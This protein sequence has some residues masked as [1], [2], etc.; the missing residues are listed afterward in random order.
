MSKLLVWDNA[1]PHHP[2]QVK[3]AAL[4]AGFELA[5]L[6]FR[7]PELMPLE[8]LGRRLKDEVAANRCYA[9]MAELAKRAVACWIG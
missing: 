3:A 4:A 2:R 6:P 1:P 7:S 9:T 8:D 5:V